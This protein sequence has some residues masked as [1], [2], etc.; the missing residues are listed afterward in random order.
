M[1]RSIP[2]TPETSRYSDG[3]SSF[4]ANGEFTLVVAVARKKSS[5]RGH[6]DQDDKFAYITLNRNDYRQLWIEIRSSPKGNILLHQ[7]QHGRFTAVEY[8]S[9]IEK[10]CA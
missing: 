9:A 7:D 5:P 1:E 6:I 4:K 10:N 2:V 3:L 8:R